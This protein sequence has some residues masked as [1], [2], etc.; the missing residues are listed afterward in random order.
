MKENSFYLIDN[1]YIKLINNLG[2]KYGDSKQRPIIVVLKIKILTDYFG[3][4]Q[5]VIFLTE[6]KIKFPSIITTYNYQ[7]MIF[8]LRIIILVTPI[9]RHYIELVTAF[10]SQINILLKHTFRKAIP[11][12]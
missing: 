10:L 12:A 6:L 3:L 2:G 5:Q 11:F 8:V 9:N 7:K 1:T 4:Y